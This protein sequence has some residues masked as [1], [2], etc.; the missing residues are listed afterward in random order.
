[1]WR[2]VAEATMVRVVYP[3][4]KGTRLDGLYLS[5]FVYVARIQEA[6]FSSGN[7]EEKCALS[8]PLNNLRSV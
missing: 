8:L 5:L 7:A 6:L 4:A 1:M 2:E 3:V